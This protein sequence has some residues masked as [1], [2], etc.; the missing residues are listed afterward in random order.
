MSAS[1]R[2]AAVP[3]R[4]RSGQLL[5]VQ[6]GYAESEDIQTLQR[7]KIDAKGVAAATPKHIH[8]SQCALFF[9]RNMMMTDFNRP[10]RD[11]GPKLG[12]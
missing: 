9:I 10:M 11:G 6:F 7:Q 1:G 12:D 8:Y 2:K 4:F 3:D 5:N